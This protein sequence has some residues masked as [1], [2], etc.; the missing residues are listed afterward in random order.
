MK[1]RTLPA[2]EVVTGENPTATVIWLHGLGAD[3][4]D[5]EPIVPELRLPDDLNIRFVFPHAPSMPVSIN[6]GFI[7]P[8]WY[9]IKHTDI[10]YQQD[11]AGI[12]ESGRQIQLL[13]EREEL[14]GVS[15]ERIILAGFSQGGA[16]ALHIGLRQGEPLAGIMALSCYLPIAETVESEL[17]EES[18]STQ[19]FMAHGVNDPV[20]PY[21]LGDN[22]H[23]KLESL[24]YSVEWHS[25]PMEHSVC[26]E[27]VTKI[28]QWISKVLS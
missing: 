26:P 19:I 12:R 24:G 13:I 21:T 16:M 3:G 25:Y 15:S 23:R 4:R 6:G 5:F 11:E 22:S 2:V 8:A 18:K 1:T 14:R 17:F 7:M 10:G 20:V 27:E 28:G 9:D